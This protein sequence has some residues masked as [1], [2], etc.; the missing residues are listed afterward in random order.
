[1]KIKLNENEKTIEIKDGLKF[2][3]L[4]F[5][6]SL[7]ISTITSFSFLVFVSEKTRL[8]LIV[9]WIFIGITSAGILMYYIFRK[10][11]SEKMQLS[12]IRTLK[13]NNFFGRKSLS[14]K[15]TN[16]KLRDL[17]TMEKNSDI[18]EMKKMFENIGIKTT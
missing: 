8:E 4:M 18:I 12:D 9:F 3:H 14:L 6:I 13:E 10:T 7:I 5:K 17:L 2:Q 15:L 1:M 16:G 11:A